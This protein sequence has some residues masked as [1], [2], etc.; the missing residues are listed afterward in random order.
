MIRRLLRRRRETGWR[1]GDGVALLISRRVAAAGAVAALGGFGLAIA[2]PDLA[3]PSAAAQPVRPA[4]LPAHCAAAHARV[5]CT[6]VYAGFEQVF[7]APTGV[8]SVTVMATGAPG[9]SVPESEGTTPG[10]MGGTATATV[11]VAAGSNLYVEVGGPGL[12]GSHGGGW[13]GGGSAGGPFGGS[14]G[15]ASDVRTVSCGDFCTSSDS[16]SLSSRLVVAGGGGGAGGAAL[17]DSG[18]LALGGNGGSAGSSGAE[19]AADDMGSSGQ[20]GV[21]ATLTGGGSGGAGGISNVVFAINGA[22][23]SAGSQGQGGSGGATET[24]SGGGGGGAGFY[25]GGGGGG[26]VG[27]IGVP[28]YGTGSGGGG[29][30]SSYAPG[31]TVGVAVTA[32]PSVV[33]SYAE[34][35]LTMS[36]PANIA[37]DATSASGKVVA[38]PLPVVTDPSQSPPP[39]PACEPASGSTF[40]IRTTTVT[41]TV[42]DPQDGNSPLSV[43][44]SVVVHPVLRV[45]TSSLPTAVA[46]VRYRKTLQASGGAP[47][48][49]WALAPG[50]LALPRGLSLSS[51]GVIWGKPVAKGLVKVTV[52]VRD[53]A[54]SPS[55]ATRLLTIRVA[56]PNLRL[57]I[58]QAGIF[59]PGHTGT[60]LAKVSNHGTTTTG[61]VWLVT[62]LPAGLRLIA[63]RGSGW[64]CHHRGGTLSCEHRARLSANRSSVLTV[65]VHVSARKGSRVGVSATATATGT[66]SRASIRIRI[67]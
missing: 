37:V 58:R 59:R 5:T 33:I 49:I 56:A 48:Y 54:T 19:G 60:I 67:R 51:S 52:Q 9:A 10:G 22:P 64:W 28:S 39:S 44:F 1:L 45:V 55:T 57:N 23:G 6:Y 50:S 61:P 62:H 30:G 13:N 14:G 35:D 38:Y 40:P 46:H 24:T 21:A 42:S 18:P 26:G 36:Q 15:G 25:G 4:A 41:C 8:T 65:R 3:V 16:A 7:T 17:D 12:T 53:S 43:S 27:T 11:A 63:A 47:R 2:P 31:G 66:A 34:P 20:G 29:G 32:T